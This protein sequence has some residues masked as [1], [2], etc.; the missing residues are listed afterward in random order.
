MK[1][2]KNCC[3]VFLTI[4]TVMSFGQVRMPVITFSPPYANDLPLDKKYINENF[5]DYEDIDGS[6]Y[7]NK[8]F[9]NGTFYVKDTLAIKH[10]I[11]YNLYTD[12]M[13]YQSEGLNYYVGS[14]QSLSR[15]ILGESV[16]IYLPFIEKGGYFELFEP[17]KCKLVQKRKVEFRHSETKPIVGLIKSSYERI[18]DVFYLVINQ[19]QVFRVVNM[20]SVMNALQ[21]Q[22][23]KIEIFIKQEKIRN[24]KKENLIKIVKYYNSL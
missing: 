10:P 16:F 24:T 1:T 12:Q 6:P 8:E 13:E 22:R 2:R 14:P 15:I 17:G 7:L 9:V 18:P 20:N 23:P 21:D 5:H 11:R 3:I 19:N 4:S